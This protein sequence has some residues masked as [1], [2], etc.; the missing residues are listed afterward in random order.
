M[1]TIGCTIR[2]FGSWPPIHEEGEKCGFRAGGG[3]ASGGKKTT[4][5]IRAKAIAWVK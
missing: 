1:G 4:Q 3:A 2:D 5:K